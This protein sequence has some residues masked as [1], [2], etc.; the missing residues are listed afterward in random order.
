ML[1]MTV[2]IGQ[3][4]R[5]RRRLM[6]ITQVQLC[7]RIGT[8]QAYLSMM[9]KGVRNPSIEML[10]RITESLECSIKLIAKL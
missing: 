6:D 2:D 8:T 5:E 1:K 4:I 9:E 10:Y 3:Q 7:K